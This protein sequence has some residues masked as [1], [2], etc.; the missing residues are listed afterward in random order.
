LIFSLVLFCF[1]GLGANVLNG[2]AKEGM[3]REINGHRFI[4]KVETCNAFYSAKYL[5][6]KHKFS[7]KLGK[8]RCPFTQQ[9]W[10]VVK[11]MHR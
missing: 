3:T 8:P 11:T 10:L 5:H 9:E 7:T 4:C 2:V 6:Q 1:V